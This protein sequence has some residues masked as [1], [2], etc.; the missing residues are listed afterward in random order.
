MD[1]GSGQLRQRSLTE[2]LHLPSDD[3]VVLAYKDTATNLIYLRRSKAFDHNGF[4]VDLRG[5][6]YVVLQYWMEL[7]PSA[8]QPWDKLCDAL[9]GEG[10]YNLDEALSKLRLRPLH[11]ALWQVLNL[12]IIKGFVDVVNEFVKPEISPVVGTSADNVVKAQSPKATEESTTEMDA[13]HSD[14][15]SDETNERLDPRIVALVEKAETFFQIVAK[16]DELGV[17]RMKSFSPEAPEIIAAELSGGEESFETRFKTEVV[18]AAQVVRLKKKFSFR[19]PVVARSLLPGSHSESRPSAV[20]APVI[21]WILFS[22]FSPDIEGIEALFDPLQ[23]RAAL[24]QSFSQVGI[25]GEDSWRAA[26][27]VR[28]LLLHPNL[29]ANAALQAPGFWED[30]D[31]R[32][33]AGVSE[34]FGTTYINKERFEELLWWM[35]LPGLINTVMSGEIHSELFTEIEGRVASGCLAAQKADYEVERLLEQLRVEA[36]RQRRFSP[37]PL[38][39][40][41]AQPLLARISNPNGADQQTESS[42]SKVQ[43]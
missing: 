18:A 35:E 28:A 19:W 34:A 6:Q 13:A 37:K 39:E 12:G 32:W 8:E 40:E 16:S 24:A 20:W 15:D 21:A 38:L 17:G 23:L 36:Q 33:L 29:S 11:E 9:H 1:K 2:A 30:P 26:A 41:T 14:G 7:R 4:S 27:R 3:G 10:V 43:D 25:T 31:V 22:R 5:Y 42:E